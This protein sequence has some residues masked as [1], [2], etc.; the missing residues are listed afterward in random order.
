MFDLDEKKMKKNVVRI[1]LKK[2]KRK[3][4]I[5]FLHQHDKLNF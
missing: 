1:L 5:E 3:K 4:R 2:K